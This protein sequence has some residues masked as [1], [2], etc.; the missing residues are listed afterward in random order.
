MDTPL[1]GQAAAVRSSSQPDFPKKGSCRFAVPR[2][3]PKDPMDSSSAFYIASLKH[4]G[5]QHEHITWWGPAWRGY[6][7]VVGD[8]I[9]VYSAEE[10]AKLNDGQAD[11][12]V[13][14]EAV[15]ALLSPEPHYSRGRLYDQRGPVVD[16]SRKNWGQLL[17]ARLRAGQSEGVNP[18]PV[19]F[20]GARRATSNL[21]GAP[22]GDVAAR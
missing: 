12:A 22:A 9:G 1:R 18:K 10:A 6:T 2:K 21:Q 3:Y 16:N 11:I 13:P 7:P 15:H 19:P 14:V 20:R 8:H 5:K 17:A 4:T